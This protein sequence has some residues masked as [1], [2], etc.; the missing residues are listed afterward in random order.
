MVFRPMMIGRPHHNPSGEKE[1]R[2]THTDASYIP[3]DK[4]PSRGGF[5]IVVL[6]VVALFQG[7]SLA[8]YHLGGAWVQDILP[9]YTH[10]IALTLGTLFLF[11]A[12]QLLGALVWAVRYGVR[13]PPEPFLHHKPDL[14]PVTVQIPLRNEPLAVARVAIDAAFDLDYP[15]DRLEIQVIDNSDTPEQFAPIQKYLETKIHEA[16]QSRKAPEVTF[17]HREGTQGFKAGNLNLGRM[18]A[19]GEFFLILDADSTV[20][21]QTLLEALPCFDDPKIGFVQLRID[22][23]NQDENIITRAA[24]VTIR[25]RYL[26]MQVR[27]AQGLVQFDGHNGLFRAAALEAV[28]GWAEDVSE[29]LVTS[30]RLILKGYRGRYLDLPSGE[31]VP[32]TF[33]DLYRQRQRWAEGTAIFVKREGL[34]ILKSKDLAWHEKL[35]LFYASINILVEAFAWLILFTFAPLPA[36]TFAVVL[37]V[38]SVIP[39]LLASPRAPFAAVRQQITVILVISA[40][41][42]GLA[43]GALRGLRGRPQ[44]FSITGKAVRNQLGLRQLLSTYGATI[45][46][47]IVFFTVASLLTKDM[48]E[49]LGQYLP[50]TV[51]MG[52]TIAG[53]I[54]LN[55]WAGATARPLTS[56]VLKDDR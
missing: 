2:V 34:S 23:T 46:A 29:D 1:K 50:G 16:N 13:P 56:G 22:P 28:N 41:L 47:G 24:A 48:A 14:P 20:R 21:P 6:L 42:P 15:T 12:V 11:R 51:I 49:F 17:L 36:T 9:T 38:M 10:V 3:K 31:L 55:Y 8:A 45:G 40:I 30:V 26:T 7:A 35:D 43:R 5:Y 25:A 32:R 27:D 37:L 39:T 18:Q 54:L 33:H 19:K 44:Q 53:P 52:A 4:T